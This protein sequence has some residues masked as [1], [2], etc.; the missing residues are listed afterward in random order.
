MRAVALIALL[1]AC[2][3]SAADQV[4][5]AIDTDAD[6]PRM[7]DRVR[8][9]V[10]DA[11]GNLLCP[12]CTHDAALTSTT[13]WPLSFGIL[14]RPQR[15]FAQ[16]VFYRAG[17]FEGQNIAPSSSL[18][19]IVEVGFA[20]GIFHERTLLSMDCAGI[21]SN[22]AARTTCDDAKN[23]AAPI[24]LANND[25]FADSKLGTWHSD[26]RHGCSTPAGD[27]TDVY[28]REICVP[29]GYYWM[30]TTRHFG[31]S[32][33]DPIPEHVVAVAS[34]WIDQFPYTVGRYRAARAAGFAKRVHQRR[35]PDVIGAGCTMD[36][37]T[38]DNIP[39]TCVEPSIAEAICAFEGKRLISEAEWEWMAGGRE[40]EW[41][42]PWGNDERPCA[43]IM[44]ATFNCANLPFGLFVSPAVPVGMNANDVTVDGVVDVA[45]SV[46]ATV[47]DDG[48]LYS[49]PCW[50]PGTYGV[51]PICKADTP[52]PITRGGH[53][54][55]YG[56]H[57]TRATERGFTDLPAWGVRCGRD[58]D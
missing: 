55:N 31:F 26:L 30:G 37:N 20:D 36:D 35:D 12:T 16:I 56:P 45:A 15:T 21:P 22:I 42:Y 39:L 28:A 8:I 3:P 34:F 49:A 19:R 41:D 43:M 54:I 51:S 27:S 32:P 11:D 47:A 52:N 33:I 2:S 9:R 4:V 14:R 40:N 1:A 46:A 29:G 48:M 38:A 25:T 58:G 13:G 57:W 23:L 18:E 10:I 5:L 17:Q 50:Q 24:R 44:G 53:S 7:F 6:V